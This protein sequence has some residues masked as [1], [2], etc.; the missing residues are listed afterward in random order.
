MVYF[1][2]RGSSESCTKYMLVSTVR[3]I[4][5]GQI[6]ALTSL[7]T[8]ESKMELDTHANTMVLGK[9]CL[10]IQDF[11]K[12][13][14]VSGRNASA[15][16]TK[17]PTVSGVVAYNHPHMGVT[18]MLIWHQSIYLVTMDNHLICLMQ[19]RVQ[20]VTIHDMPKIFVKN[21]TNHSHA[22]VVSDPVDP[23]ND[24]VIPLELVG[25]TSVFSVRTPTRQ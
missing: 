22:I 14:S 17:C 15:G 5:I 10:I 8:I 25:V 19:C 13:V 12:A 20:G 2:G 1:I 9:N 21:P 7:Q 23:K 11:G 3:S 18:Y 24:L 16:S 6:A 4:K